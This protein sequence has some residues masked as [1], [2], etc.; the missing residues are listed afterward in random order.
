M[1]AKGILLTVLVLVANYFGTTFSIRF[2]WFLKAR[3]LH[4]Y[5]H[6]LDINFMVADHFWDKCLRTY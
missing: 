4:E 1:I 2:K 6:D 5:H 3:R